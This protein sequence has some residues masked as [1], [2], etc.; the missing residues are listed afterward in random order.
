MFRRFWFAIAVVCLAGVPLRAD[1]RVA[2]DDALKAVVKKVDPV[3]P[4][5]AKQMHVTGKVTV[6]VT[7][8]TTGSVTDVKVT[9][10][11]ALLTPTVLD[12]VKKWKFTP[13]NGAT[14]EPTKVVASIDFDFKF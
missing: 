6:D 10:G 14:G 4:P 9:S 12:A 3:Y 7:V 8:D 11:N 13:F 5:I 1:M 2:A